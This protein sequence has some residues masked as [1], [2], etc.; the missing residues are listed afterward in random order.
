MKSISIV[1][2][3]A[4]KN[5]ISLKKTTTG[6][7]PI[8]VHMHCTKLRIV[9]T[10]W[11]SAICQFRFGRVNSE[12]NKNL[13]IFCSPNS[14]RRPFLSQFLLFLSLQSY[15]HNLTIIVAFRSKKTFWGFPNLKTASIS[16]N[17]CPANLCKAEIA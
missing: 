7:S 13:W 3:K 15:D 8:W 14:L 5:Y 2:G 10:L 4:R 16:E 17:E 11:L 6:F 1:L 9:A 12:P